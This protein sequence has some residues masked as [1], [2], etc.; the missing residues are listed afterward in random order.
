MNCFFFTQCGAMTIFITIRL[1]F[2]AP[3]MAHWIVN[4]NCS[5]YINE[6][7]IWLWNDYFSFRENL[8][9]EEEFK[10]FFKIPPFIRKNPY[11]FM[12]NISQL[13]ML[14]CLRCK[15][16]LAD[17]WMISEAAWETPAICGMQ[18]ADCIHVNDSHPAH[19]SM[20][21]APLV[22]SSR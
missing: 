9:C 15:N 1:C 19:L 3:W 17:T 18:T 11:G 12:V 22:A 21:I 5:K 10:I 2:V 4:V 14:Y 13:Y 8:S 20:G 16:T 6:C 7:T